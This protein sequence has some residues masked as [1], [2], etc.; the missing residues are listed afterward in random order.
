M[1][2]YLPK[3]RNKGETMSSKNDL[4]R[5]ANLPGHFRGY[6]SDLKKPE[7]QELIMD[8]LVALIENGASQTRAVNTVAVHHAL[9]VDEVEYLLRCATEEANEVMEDTKAH[10]LIMSGNL[11]LLQR[12]FRH[13]AS[14]GLQEPNPDD[15]PLVKAQTARMAQDA[16]RTALA[17]QKAI[18]DLVGLRDAKYSPKGTPA[19]TVNI[20]GDPRNVAAVKALLGEG[21]ITDAEVVDEDE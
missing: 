15:L 4:T 19:V 5:I 12:L 18:Q 6:N 2:L 8:E 11:T 3:T 10:D 21:D 9:P 7:V 20:Q 16:T 13:H 14:Q 17:A 1:G